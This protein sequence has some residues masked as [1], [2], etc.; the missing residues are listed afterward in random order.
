M[1]KHVMNDHTVDMERYKEVVATTNAKGKKHK[2][3]KR[4]QL[5]PSVKTEYYGS[6]NPYG[7]N[8]VAQQRFL[9]DLV[10]YIVEGYIVLCAVENPWLWPLVSRCNPKVRFPT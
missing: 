6:S 8:V 9:E 2:C 1:M 4:K 3:K 5:N 10:L 7:K